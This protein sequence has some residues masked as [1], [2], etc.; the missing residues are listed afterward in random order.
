MPERKPNFTPQQ[1]QTFQ[2]K[3]AISEKQ[4]ENI[5]EVFELN[6]ELAEITEKASRLFLVNS[7]Q[8][9]KSEKELSS[10]LKEYYK[11]HSENKEWLNIISV[12]PQELQRKIIEKRPEGTVENVIELRE[13]LNEEWNRI[14]ELFLKGFYEGQGKELE[15]VLTAGRFG[16]EKLNYDDERKIDEII[17]NIYTWFDRFASVYLHKFEIYP[18]EN[19][20]QTFGMRNVSLDEVSLNDV[21]KDKDWY[22][23]VDLF[24]E[25]YFRFLAAGTNENK[26]ELAVHLLDFAEY[27]GKKSS[28]E[29][30]FKNFQLLQNNLDPSKTKDKSRTFSPLNRVESN[31]KTNILWYYG[32][33]KNLKYMRILPDGYE[34]QNHLKSYTKPGLETSNHAKELYKEYLESIF[35]ESK[36]KDVLWHGS[37]DVKKIEV[38][39]NRYFNTDLNTYVNGV[40][41][42]FGVD[43]AD[44]YK[45]GRR[46]GEDLTHS[47]TV[48]AVLNVRNPKEAIDGA[49]MALI[50]DDELK[51]LKAD[52]ADA[53]MYMNEEIAVFDNQQIHILGTDNDIEEFKKW[54]ENQNEK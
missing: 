12:Y 21:R 25:Q 27:F 42:S 9:E 24:I 16:R 37:K 40:Y 34:I 18:D 8:K 19:V 7:I 22:T 45:K 14:S 11:K 6:P 48:A 54:A 15:N 23:K 17:S 39:N 28:T 30:Y 4:L 53:L 29:E 50:N 52:G 31:N 33:Q 36:V 5:K 2:S 3:E 41:F 49:R 47:G 44:D 13:R 51:Q 26:L 38:F 10:D 32:N 1:D 35:P 43:Y 46:E 20:R